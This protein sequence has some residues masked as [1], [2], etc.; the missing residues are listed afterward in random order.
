MSLFE[1]KMKDIKSFILTLFV[2]PEPAPS[3][4]IKPLTND[5]LTAF[6]KAALDQI[7]YFRSL[8][9]AANV[10]GSADLDTS[11]QAK[12]SL[13]TSTGNLDKSTAGVGELIYGKVENGDLSVDTCICNIF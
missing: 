7:N 1:I 10:T 2:T 12:V 8:H 13:I 5:C 9:F 3:T 4:Y 11:A 6:R